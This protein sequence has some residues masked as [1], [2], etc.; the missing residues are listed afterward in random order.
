MLIYS[1]Q[2]TNFASAPYTKSGAE[3]NKSNPYD[4]KC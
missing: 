3:A 1:L 4:L 2:F